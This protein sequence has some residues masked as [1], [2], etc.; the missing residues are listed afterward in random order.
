MSQAITMC[1]AQVIGTRI[2]TDP[3]QVHRLSKI[4]G[5]RF[6]GFHLWQRF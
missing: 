2:T 6:D 5:R 1:I 3:G 4:I